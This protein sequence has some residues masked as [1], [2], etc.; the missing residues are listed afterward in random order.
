MAVLPLSTLMPFAVIV[1][2]ILGVFAVMYIVDSYE[3]P[4]SPSDSIRRILRSTGG[5]A[6]GLIGAHLLFYGFHDLDELG[7]TLIGI[8]TAFLLLFMTDMIVLGK[9]RSKSTERPEDG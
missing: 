9:R 3:A 1:G 6:V 5:V 8:L 4:V 2:L 7:V